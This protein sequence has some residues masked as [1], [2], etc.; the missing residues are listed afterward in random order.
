METAGGKES[1]GTC[2]FDPALSGVAW[3]DFLEEVALEL[4]FQ[5]CSPTPAG[6]LLRCI[7]ISVLGANRHPGGGSGGSQG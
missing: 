2:L 4:N 1:W 5:R 3:E 6:R 7:D